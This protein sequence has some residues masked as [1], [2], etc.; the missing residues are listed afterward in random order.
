M[1]NE[2]EQRLNRDI[3]KDYCKV[4][5]TS[6]LAIIEEEMGV[7]VAVKMVDLFMGTIISIPTR[8]ALK[9]AIMPMNIQRNLPVALSKDSD[10]FKKVVKQL[11][12]I[13]KLPK[14]AIIEMNKTGKY[15]R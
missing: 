9:R 14:R 3:V 8:E 5:P 11:S 12:Q 2:K 13:Y 4:Q 6:A 7:D 15:T 1:E 10:L